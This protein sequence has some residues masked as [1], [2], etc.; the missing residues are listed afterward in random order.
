M[1][2]DVIGRYLKS[3]F[4]T[5]N[6]SF[7]DPVQSPYAPGSTPL[8]AGS[9][10]PAG[11]APSPSGGGGGSGPGATP[12]PSTPPAPALDWHA[13][14]TNWGFTPEIVDELDRI[15]RTYS[16]ASQASAS[17]IAYIRGTDWYATTFPGIQEGMKLGVISDEASYRA[18]T[19]QL[20]DLYHRY[21]N[22]DVTGADVATALKGGFTTA[23]VDAHFQGQAYV[24]A[25]QNDIQG[26]LGAYDSEGQATPDQLSALGDQ[27][28]GLDNMLG[29]EVQR[30]IAAAKQKLAGAFN[31]TLFNP[32][33][34]VTSGGRLAAT[35]LAGGSNPSD[36]GA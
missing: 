7:N 22:R 17:A 11:P 2:D 30:R 3:H 31:G 27:Q 4:P 9:P 5:V 34:G 18:Y 19:N 12:P 36:I 33:L 26:A 20:N 15:F 13:Y 6:V 14:L 28:A 8:P 23:H 35:S 21:Y 16:D 29:P 10:T 25:N 24:A 32:N 1:A